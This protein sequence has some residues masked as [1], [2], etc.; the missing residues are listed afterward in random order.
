MPF[1]QIESCDRCQRV[2]P[3]LKTAAAPEL[4]HVAVKNGVWKQWG[5]DLVGPLVE[6][7]RGNKYII[8]ATDYFSKWPEAQ[9]SARKNAIS[10]ALF[11]Y[12]LFCRYGAAEVIIS[13]QGRGFVNAVSVLKFFMFRTVYNLT[14]IADTIKTARR[15]RCTTSY[16]ISI[17]PSNKRSPRKKQPNTAAVKLFGV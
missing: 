16:L 3:T 5:I 8:G 11:L 1:I 12:D 7:P 13:D 10:V 14:G 4:H 2:N 6:T 9:P 17:S 15:L